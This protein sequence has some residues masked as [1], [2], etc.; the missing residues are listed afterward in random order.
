LTDELRR[1]FKARL[2]ATDREQIK[3]AADRYFDGDR[4]QAVAVIS[5][6]EKLKAANAELAERPLA[7]HQI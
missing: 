7:L 2:L 4:P 1:E 3:A 6:E 5:N